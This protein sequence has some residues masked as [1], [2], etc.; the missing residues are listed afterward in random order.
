MGFD[1]AET[2]LSRRIVI[3][4]SRYCFGATLHTYIATFRVVKYGYHRFGPTESPLG[5]TECKLDSPDT[6]FFD[7]SRC[8]T[9][10]FFLGLNVSHAFL[11]VWYKAWLHLQTNS[12]YLFSQEIVRVPDLERELADPD[13]VHQAF[14]GE[15][16]SE[17]ESSIDVESILQVKSNALWRSMTFDDI[18]DDL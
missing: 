9:S 3:N 10:W 6:G 12:M 14:P 13:I 7:E 4:F 8:E 16:R 11:F 2:I 1:P 15:R 17:E 5:N 18:T